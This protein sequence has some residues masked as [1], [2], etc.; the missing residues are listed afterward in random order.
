MPMPGFYNKSGH[1]EE[2]EDKDDGKEAT[3]MPT[4]NDPASA[5]LPPTNSRKGGD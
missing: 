2:D 3:M 4:S 1:F 5:P